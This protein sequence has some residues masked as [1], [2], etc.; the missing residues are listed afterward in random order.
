MNK[1]S[2]KLKIPTNFVFMSFLIVCFTE[3]KVSLIYKLHFN[4][5][6]F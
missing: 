1:Y 3:V 6:S 5:K 2:I 4:L